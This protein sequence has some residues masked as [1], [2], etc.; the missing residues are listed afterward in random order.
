MRRLLLT[1]ASGS[2]FYSGL[3]PALGLGEISLHSAL[4]QPLDAEIELLQAADLSADEIRVRLASA[5]EFERSGVERFFFLNDLRFTPVLGGGRNLIRV[6]SSRPV[7]EPYLN[8]IVEVS[9]PG[10]QLLREYTLLIDP[11]GSAASSPLAAPV[12]ALPAAA[13]ASQGWRPQPARELPAAKRGER[14]RVQRGDNLW[15]IAGRLLP[16][17]SAGRE[18]LMADLF[19]LN[20]QAF[21]AGSPDRL[22]ADAELLLPDS[23][24]PAASAPAEAVATAEAAAP[25]EP[26]AEADEAMPAAAVVAAEQLRVDAELAEA[27]ARNAEL[28]SSLD[29][30]HGQLAALQ[31]QMAEK[32]RQLQQ[33]REQLAQR[34]AAPAAS[35]PAA[36]ESAGGWGLW[37]LGALLLLVLLAGVLL[38]RRRPPLPAAEPPRRPQAEPRLEV[39]VVPPAEPVVTPA[40]VAEPELKRA[41]VASSPAAPRPPATPADPLEGANIYIAYGHFAEAA[42]TLRRALAEQPQRLDLRL[43]LFEVCGE[44]GDAAA[45]FELERQL[46]EMGASPQQL[47]PIRARYAG[48]QRPQAQ[49]ALADAVL[50]L[51]E[52]DARQ[53]LQDDSQ[54]NLDDLSLDADWD[55][56]NALQPE[57]PARIRKGREQAPD[58]QFR[59]DLKQLPEVQE[60]DADKELLESFAELPQE[61]VLDEEFVDAFSREPVE[62]GPLLDGDLEHL[63]GSRD[64]LVKLNMALAYIEQGDIGSACDIL[65]QLISEGDEQQRARARELLAKIA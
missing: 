31:A 33:I 53:P 20:P 9:R 11:P 28:Q 65:N 54:L 23:L 37:L 48:L 42:A 3:L 25:A 10:G 13:P 55:L 51:D 56:A 6:I 59:S 52:P 63:A 26:V 62:R 64:Q 16:P 57:Q 5:E 40:P 58:P 49:D 18:A 41:P 15:R 61:Q 22:R 32:D 2:A 4:N 29:A 46:R 35:L 39:R 21:S 38:A 27:G 34:Q 43:R 45:F 30:L 12:A 24:F 47:D 1:L 8:F 36:R 50:Q 19:V 14:Y 7:R 44:L 60:V 17:G